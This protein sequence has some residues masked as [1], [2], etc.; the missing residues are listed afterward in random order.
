ME[1]GISRRLYSVQLAMLVDSRGYLPS[2]HN[3]VTRSLML[4]Y[5]SA[6][7]SKVGHKDVEKL[8]SSTGDRLGISR[9]LESVLK[10]PGKIP[11]GDI[12]PISH[13]LFG[14]RRSTLEFKLY[15][16][17][18]TL[19][20]EDFRGLTIFI[21]TGDLIKEIIEA[22]IRVDATLKELDRSQI[23]Y[24]LKEGI[25]KSQKRVVIKIADNEH[26]VNQGIVDAAKYF[27]PGELV[28]L[29]LSKQRKA[30][31]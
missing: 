20:R 19:E 22:E 23:P 18:T 2:V 25:I 16:V 13:T 29:R 31:H 30:S 26:R 6:D 10:E 4:P 28:D 17:K 1:S 3:D 21:S 5:A 8:S 24:H 27:F 12:T 7:S 15:E 14:I 9:A 11:P